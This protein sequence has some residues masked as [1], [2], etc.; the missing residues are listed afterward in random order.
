LPRDAPFPM[1]RSCF[2]QILKL[3][4]SPSEVGNTGGVFPFAKIH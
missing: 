1:R 4:E 2:I 3:E